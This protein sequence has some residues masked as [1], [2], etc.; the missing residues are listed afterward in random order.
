VK[1][2]ISHLSLLKEFSPVKIRPIFELV[3]VDKR[4]VKLLS[5]LIS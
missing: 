2:T 1:L 3:D 4:P 5:V